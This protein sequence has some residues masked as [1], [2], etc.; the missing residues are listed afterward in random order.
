MVAFFDTV[1]G[2]MAEV[3]G[4]QQPQETP[5]A[6]RLSEDLY[7]QYRGARGEWEKQ[8]RADQEFRNGVQWTHAEEQELARRDQAPIVVNVLYPA[9]EQ[10][11]AMLTTRTP[12]F[13]T[14]ARDD[15]DAKLA[16]VITALMSYVW[17]QS[18][19][20]AVLKQAIDDYYVTG[21]GYLLTY[22]DAL[23]D[24]GHGE[25]KLVAVPSLEVFPDPASQDRWLSDAAHIIVAKTL[26]LEQLQLLWPDLRS[27]AGNLKPCSGEDTGGAVERHAQEGQQ[28]GPT[29]ALGDAEVYL[30][31]DRYSRITLNYYMVRDPQSGTERAFLPDEYAAYLK[32]PALIQTIGGTAQYVVL[33]DDVAQLL[34]LYNQLGPQYHMAQNPQTGQVS[35]VSGLA[36]ED[37]E[38]IPN[39][40]VTIAV[41][42]QRW[43][44]E[45]GVVEVF[46]TPLP[47][48]QRIFSVGG[49]LVYEGVLPVSNYPIVPIMALH[50]RNPYPQSPVRLVRGLQEYI[51]KLR[52]LIIAHATSSTNVKVLIPRGSVDK[53]ELR[54][55]LGR[56]GAGA[57]FFDAEMGTPVV[58]API[59]LPNE[60]YHNEAQARGD[61][62]QILGVYALM[63]GDQQNAPATY[64]GT[65]AIDEFGQRRIR[66]Q[67]DDV[68][69]SLNRLAKV[70]LELIQALYRKH[71]IFR[72]IQPNDVEV[73]QEVNVPMYS[74]FSKEIIRVHNDVSVGQYDVIVVSGSMLPSN[75]WALFEGYMRLFERGVIDQLELLRKTEVVDT[76]G[77]MER[78]GQ[79][80]RLQQAITALQ[81]TV[82]QLQGDLQ[83]AQR[84]AVHASQ[85]V[86]LYK[87]KA[88]LQDE[89]AKVAAAS[90]VFRQRMTDVLTNTKESLAAPEL[91]SMTEEEEEAPA[92]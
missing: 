25:V 72:L 66:S 54:E 57:I 28:V 92:I 44:V 55:E 3:E 23:A 46:V 51:N 77:V 27:M 53:K 9:I 50:N 86:E 21:V 84:E 11:K 73:T 35:P 2:Q 40:D 14:T 48:I 33:E 49:Q 20:N 58:L 37:P 63:Q 75:R 90:S 42:D 5:E 70:V 62:E 91:F 16:H 56:A 78:F 67:Q 79:I 89:T 1:T 81:Q 64:R 26:T 8:A 29:S 68:E 10:A 60:L 43:M 15:S 31:L 36:A 13:A 22:W 7:E 47:R 61:I 76:P 19:G 82:K 34:N 12:R 6:V 52:S 41:V 69:Q 83:T 32:E 24:R 30:A 80:Q 71:K 85:R 65:I 4:S 88:D 18:H 45:H 59:P 39:S 38:A 17:D 74:D 87:F